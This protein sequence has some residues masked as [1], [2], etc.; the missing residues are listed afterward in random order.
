M[1]LGRE[2]LGVSAA[3]HGASMV[4]KIAR[5]RSL[6]R[7]IDISHSLF[8]NRVFRN[9]SFRNRAFEKHGVF[10]FSLLLEL[11]HPVGHLLHVG[12]QKI[13]RNRVLLPSEGVDKWSVCLMRRYSVNCPINFF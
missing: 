5:E 7:F 6:E 10:A 13:H 11:Q 12:A 4:S 9:R 3:G 8:R 2:F 1:K